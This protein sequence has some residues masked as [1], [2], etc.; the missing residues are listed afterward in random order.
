[1]IYWFNPCLI[2]VHNAIVNNDL[3]QSE[4]SP[5]TFSNKSEKIHSDEHLLVSLDEVNALKVFL[6][7]SVW[8]LL[9]SSSHTVFPGVCVREVVPSLE[10]EHG[11]VQFKVCLDL[12]RH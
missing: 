11:R 10:I 5:F 8:L 2:L 12:M 7:R 4:T 1:M 6:Q 3:N 9:T